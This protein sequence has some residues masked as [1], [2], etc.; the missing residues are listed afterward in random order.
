[1][2]SMNSTMT[3]RI[4]LRRLDELDS[5]LIVHYFLLDVADAAVGHAALQDDRLLAECQPMSCSEL[6]CSGNAVSTRHPPWL[7][8]LIESG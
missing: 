3:S 5:R 7:I 1:M 2:A 8:S 4:A 6:R